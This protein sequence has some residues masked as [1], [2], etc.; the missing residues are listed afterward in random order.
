MVADWPTTAARGCP[1]AGGERHAQGL[2]GR[3]VAA[4]NAGARPGPWVLAEYGSLAAVGPPLRHRL[5]VADDLG[6]VF[7]FGD[8]PFFGLNPGQVEVVGIAP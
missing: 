7:V 3:A 6:G 4:T 1:V 2:R 8:A 5:L